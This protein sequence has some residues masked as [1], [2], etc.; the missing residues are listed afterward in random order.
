VHENEGAAALARTHKD[1]ETVRVTA[2]AVGGK[3]R[4]EGEGEAD[5]ALA[6]GTANAQATKL[7]VDAYGGPNIDWRSRIS[8]VSPMR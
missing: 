4:L 2:A 7:S 5:R 3:S 8:H 1:A 6:I